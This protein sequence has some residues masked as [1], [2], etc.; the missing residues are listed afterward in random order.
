MRRDDHARR[1]A[2]LQNILPMWTNDGPSGVLSQAYDHQ[3][4]HLATDYVCCVLRGPGDDITPRALAEQQDID[5]LIEMQTLALTW[6]TGILWIVDELFDSYRCGLSHSYIDD[7]FAITTKAWDSGVESHNDSSRHQTGLDSSPQQTGSDTTSSF[8]QLAY[9]WPE[10]VQVLRRLIERTCELSQEPH[11]E[12]FLHLFGRL[13]L[14]HIKSRHLELEAS[15]Q[16]TTGHAPLATLH[17]FDLM[18]AKTGGMEIVIVAVLWFR[19]RQAYLRTGIAPPAL[20]SLQQLQDINKQTCD[21]NDLFSLISDIRDRDHNL[22]RLLRFQILGSE[23]DWDIADTYF[24][25]FSMGVARCRGHWMR[26]AQT[27]KLW[28]GTFELAA[29]E[30]MHGM[31]IWQI[32]Q[33]RYR[34]G[35]MLCQV[36]TDQ[37]L[38]PP[39]KRRR[40]IAILQPELN[41]LATACPSQE[42][43]NETESILAKAGPGEMSLHR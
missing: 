35:W 6:C 20:P 40:F 31:Y 24:K 9:R 30:L 4:Q 12:E 33:P 17:A 32:R 5:S 13:F 8:N 21:L 41:R 3:F 22:V 34:M 1:A 10:A 25:P 19:A 38:S 27:A 42:S 15:T 26:A 37:A 11:Q 23:N 18:R 39:E 29:H 43:S 2:V 16:E 7:F 36:M 14:D 28:N